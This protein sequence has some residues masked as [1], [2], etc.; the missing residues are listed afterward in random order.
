MVYIVGRFL[1]CLIKNYRLIIIKTWQILKLKGLW[2]IQKSMLLINGISYPSE[3]ISATRYQIM[4]STRNSFP[5]KDTNRKFATFFFHFLRNN[6]FIILKEIYHEFEFS[7]N[8]ALCKACW[9]PKSII[10][11]TEIRAEIMFQVLKARSYLV[12]FTPTFHFYTP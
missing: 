8:L 11:L 10:L 9:N 3:R 12:H 1:S 4:S 7:L 6:K 2:K 5:N